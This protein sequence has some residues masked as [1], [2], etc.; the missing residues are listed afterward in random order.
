MLI[1]VPDYNADGKRSARTGQARNRGAQQGPEMV[2]TRPNAQG[3]NLNRDYVRA[4]TPETKGS[5]AMFNAW[6]PDVFVDL[7]TT[8]GSYH[9]YRADVRAVAASGRGAFL[10]RQF[11]GAFARDSMLPRCSAP[12]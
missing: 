2:G 12:V 10:A 3:I 9:G 1:A 8:D 7:H 11:G 6:D 4:E 5:L